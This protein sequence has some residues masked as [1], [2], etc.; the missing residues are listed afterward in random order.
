MSAPSFA[1]AMLASTKPRWLRHISATLSPSETP[2]S[3]NA[4]A[5]AFDRRCTSA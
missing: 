5:S 2:S 4:R 1:V 3:A